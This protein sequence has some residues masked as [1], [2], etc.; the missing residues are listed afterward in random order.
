MNTR[1]VYMIDS[2]MYEDIVRERV[3]LYTFVKQL[4]FVA[5]RLFSQE[6]I[7]H[8][9]EMAYI[10][11]KQADDLFECWDIPGRFL[12]FGNSAD[13][14]GIKQIELLDYDED[15]EPEDDCLDDL[16][17]ICRAMKN[18]AAGHRMFRG[19]GEEIFSYLKT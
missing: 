12:A 18:M 14:S 5:K 19:R 6:D 9:Q 7:K 4:A 1:K 3:M 17:I 11:G 15:D 16:D 2:D 8:L 10:Y 13:L